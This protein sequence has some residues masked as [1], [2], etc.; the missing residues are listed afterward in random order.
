MKTIGP[1]PAAELLEALSSDWLV[2]LDALPVAAYVVDRDRRVRWQNA[3]SLALAGD[4]R[5]RLDAGVTSPSDL[6][7]VRAAFAEK[8]RGIPLTKI[9]V[10]ITC[11]DGLQ[12]RLAVSSIPVRNAD[13]EMIGSF[14]FASVI[15]DAVA[16]SLSPPS[17]SPREREAL[18]LLAIGCSTSEMAHHMSIA[19]ETVRNHVKRLLRRLDAHSRLEAVAKGRAMGML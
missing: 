16:P 11:A 10:M 8:R 15:D 12:R 13:G 18:T 4:V 19:E 17:L 2:S 5:G 9:E 3:A 6:A 14:G 7:R 1:S